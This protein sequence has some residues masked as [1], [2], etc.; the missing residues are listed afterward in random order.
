MSSP[1]RSPI[2]QIR[3]PLPPEAPKESAISRLLITPITFVSFLLSL[4]LIDSQNHRLRTKTHSHSPSRTQPT[5]LLGHIRDSLHG[6]VYKEVDQGPYAYVRSPNLI[7]N[8]REGLRERSASGSR[9]PR[10]SGERER[11]KAE[12]WHWHTKQR[13]MMR[14]EVE[15]A[16]KVRK[17]V[18][19]FLVLV[20]VFGVGS[21]V[22][23]GWWLLGF[24][25]SWEGGDYK[26]G[27]L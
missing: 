20:A 6:L 17:W 8:A 14:A 4:A 25:R 24:S 21:L 12:P 15:D 10:R 22:M 7:V 9:S 2:P 11:E 16:F 26:R 13:K 23:M 18:V 19:V 5:T 1:P 27:D 3:S